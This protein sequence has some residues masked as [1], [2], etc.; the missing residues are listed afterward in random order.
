MAGSLLL[1]AAGELGWLDSG[2]WPSHHAGMV[3]GLCQ[4]ATVL[5]MVH[6]W[7][8]CCS[9][10]LSLSN[11]RERQLSMVGYNNMVSTRDNKTELWCRGP[12]DTG[13]RKCITHHQRSAALSWNY[14]SSIRIA[15]HIMILVLAL[16]WFSWLAEE[17]CNCLAR[18]KRRQRWSLKGDPHEVV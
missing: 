3:V 11:K 17:P 9:S 5:I 13:L 16:A 12:L 14:R 6:F 4:S 10:S 18:I 7:C 8:Q 1:C 15:A 2:A